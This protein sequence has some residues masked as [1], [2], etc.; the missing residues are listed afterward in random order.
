MLNQN[1]KQRAHNQVFHARVGEV[2]VQTGT[3]FATMLSAKIMC[4]YEYIYMYI[5][6]IQSKRAREREREQGLIII[7]T[8]L[9]KK[10]PDN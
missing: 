4:E 9:N 8:T 3:K 5:Y 2:S 6:I 10:Y 1:H 7:T